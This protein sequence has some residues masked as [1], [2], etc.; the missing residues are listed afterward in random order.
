MMR[1]CSVLYCVFLN[2]VLYGLRLLVKDETEE[3]NVVALLSNLPIVTSDY[4]K[5]RLTYDRGYGE[6]TFVEA[7]AK[8]KNDISTIAITVGSR[9]PFIPIYES[10]TFIKT[11]RTKK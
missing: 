7:N 11:C 10:T 1:N 2:S 6:I 4:D 5:I 8:N 3:D 9:H